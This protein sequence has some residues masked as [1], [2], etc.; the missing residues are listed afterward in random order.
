MFSGIVETTAAISAAEPH[1]DLLRI[2]IERPKSFDDLH[3]G[4]SVCVDGVCLT[5][6]YFD[7]EIMRFALGLETLKVTGWTSSSVVNRVVNLERSLRLED[8]IHGHL[9]TGHVDTIGVIQDLKR[10]EGSLT[11]TI[12]FSEIFSPFIWTKGSVAINGVSL[13]VNHATETALTVGLIPET[14]KRTNLDK[15]A[16]ND[17]V[18]IEID[19]MAR[20][21]V[22]WARR[23]RESK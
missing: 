12:G 4:D 15:L 6:E 20:G 13:T 18:N 1:A 2:D 9:V 17:T 19:N 23:Q 16:L 8:R 11:L 22:N 7:L 10:S 3:P 14:L 5:V 21:L